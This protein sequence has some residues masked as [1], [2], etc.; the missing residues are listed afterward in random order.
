MSDNEKSFTA[1]YKQGKAI[2]EE[3]DEVNNGI[4]DL[5]ELVASTASVDYGDLKVMNRKELS[6]TA[7]TETEILRVDGKGYFH[8]A[9]FCSGNNTT[10]LRITIDDQCIFYMGLLNAQSYAS[11]IVVS[12]IDHIITLYTEVYLKLSNYIHWSVNNQT[13]TDLHN[14][15]SAVNINDRYESGLVAPI[16]KPIRFEKSLSIMGLSGVTNKLG[17]CSIGYT[18]D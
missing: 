15:G 8:F 13:I 1:T 17:S 18:L 11:T 6:L 2:L 9:G 16:S 3:I 14:D 5:T 7:Y 10:T 4:S 12:P